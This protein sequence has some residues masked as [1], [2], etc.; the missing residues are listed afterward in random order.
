MP[1]GVKAAAGTVGMVSTRSWRRRTASV[2]SNT[3]SCSHTT[4]SFLVRCN[5]GAPPFQERRNGFRPSSGFAGLVRGERLLHIHDM[6]QFAA[7]KPDEPVYRELLD[8]GGIQTQLAVPLRK[9]FHRSSAA[10]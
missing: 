2:A 8:Y 6:A 4:A 1:P 7:Q 3:A 5:A 9:E 10:M